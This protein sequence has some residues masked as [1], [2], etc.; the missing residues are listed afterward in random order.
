MMNN[1]LFTKYFD[2]MIRKKIAFVNRIMCGYGSLT[3]LKIVIC[4]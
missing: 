3:V 2:V 1:G 4:L